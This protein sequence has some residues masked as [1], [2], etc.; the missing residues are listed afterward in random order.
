MDSINYD[1]KLDPPQEEDFECYEDC[2]GGVSC[3]CLGKR[4]KEAGA[5]YE[6]H[7]EDYYRERAGGL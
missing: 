1:S 4:E 2:A 7:I 5:A 6:N 3:N